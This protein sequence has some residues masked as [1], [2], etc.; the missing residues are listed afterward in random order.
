[1]VKKLLK[2]TNTVVICLISLVIAFNVCVIEQGNVKA[3]GI[4]TIAKANTNYTTTNTSESYDTL[5]QAIDAMNNNS[6]P[7]IVVVDDTN[8][9]LAMKKGSIIFVGSTTITF[10]STLNGASSYVR[11]NISGYYYNTNADGTVMVGISG[12]YGKVKNYQVK[13]IPD[14][15]IT[16]GTTKD[17]FFFDYYTRNSSGNLVHTLS[18]Y[19]TSTNA[20]YSASF[21]VDKAPGFMKSGKRYY[22]F[23]GYDFFE[24]PYDVID[25]NKEP[26]GI[27]YPY[28]KFLSYRTK[29]SYTVADIN[30][31]ILNNTSSASVLRGQA[32]AFVDAQNAWGVNAIMELAF[33]NL[34]SGNGTSGYATQ[35]FNLFG[36][37]AADS[38]PDGA[39]YYKSV[40]DCVEKHAKGMLSQGYFDAY[41]FID[42]SIKN[43]NP[44]FYDS[45]YINSYTGDSRYFGTAPGN[46]AMGVNVKYASDPFH[47]EKIAGLTYLIDKYLGSKDYHKYTVGLTN[48]ATYAYAKA[49]TSS[50]KLYQYSCKSARGKSYA[51][52]LKMPVV[53][54]G[55]SGAFYKIQSDM[56]IKNSLAYFSWPYNFDTSVAY[57]LKSDIDVLP[58]E[59]VDK[60]SLMEALDNSVV[61]NRDL[62]VETSLNAL[63]L[64]YKNATTVLNNNKAKQSEVD[65]ATTALNNAY[66]NLVKIVIDQYVTSLET[67][68]SNQVS[69][70]NFSSIVVNVNVLPSNA[71]IKK[72]KYASSNPEIATIDDTG[73]LTPIKNGTTTITITSRD[74]SNVSTSFDL[75]VKVPTIISNQVTVDAPENMISGLSLDYTVENLLSNLSSDESES[76]IKVYQNNQEVTTGKL[77]TNDIVKLI[78]N[79]VAVQELKVAIISDLNGNGTC[80]ITDFITLR[81]HLLSSRILDGAFFD[82]AD[83]NRDGVVNISDFILMRN[84]LLQSGGV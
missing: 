17:R 82:A 12:L 73:K 57:V 19:R 26:V 2:F 42:S 38:N 70:N 74:G 59:N 23:N 15:W 21:T 67:D 66:S 83:L 40:A 9:I 22:S 62:Y 37:N 39:S 3:A 65:A 7:D 16:R 52:P 81:N 44:S 60:L 46:K 4:Y 80:D 77:R 1:M 56:P 24:N 31:Y 11:V 10:T 35:R 28:F 84:K 63:D 75:I 76:V 50:W 34:E 14:A 53:I 18:Y 61:D 54:L 41:A 20:N 69:V 58:S 33:A 64:A 6:D 71:T 78:V 49:S 47:G 55:T 48:K 43:N 29:S 30:R 36:I 72:L 79:N 5:A 51:G 8:K 13:L 25:P 27:F 45:G 32:Q 68:Y